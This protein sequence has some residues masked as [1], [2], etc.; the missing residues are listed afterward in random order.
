MNKKASFWIKLLKDLSIK[1]NPNRLKN[2]NSWN[3]KL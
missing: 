1:I 3:I 2:K